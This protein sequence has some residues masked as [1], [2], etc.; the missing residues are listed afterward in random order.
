MVSVVWGPASISNRSKCELGERLKRVNNLA[1]HDE[2]TSGGTTKTRLNKDK[3]VRK[4]VSSNRVKI[5]LRSERSLSID[6]MT[7]TFSPVGNGG[8]CLKHFESGENETRQGYCAFSE[9]GN[10]DFGLIR[11]Q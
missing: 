2:D 9:K 7:R 1:L 6:V 10:R 4:L 11:R 8:F 3:R 5:T